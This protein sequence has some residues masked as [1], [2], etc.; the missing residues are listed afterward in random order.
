MSKNYKYNNLRKL[1]LQLY[2]KYTISTCLNY[3]TL[4]HRTAAF[5]DAQCGYAWSSNIV[6]IWFRK[7]SQST[8]LV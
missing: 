7:P 6:P 4:Q 3:H 1:C 8:K 2:E 5:Q